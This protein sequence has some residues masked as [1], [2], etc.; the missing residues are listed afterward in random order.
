MG[1]ANTKIGSIVAITVALFIG[2]ITEMDA[3]MNPK[4]KAPPSPMK[5]FMGDG[6][7]LYLGFMIA[8]IS[9]MSPM[10][11][12]TVIATILP[13]FVLA[14]PIL[15]TA[16]AIVRR[17][18]NGRPIMEADKGHLHHKIMNVGMGQKRTVLTLYSISGIMGVAAIL[19]SRDLF[20]DALFL[21]ATAATLIYVF[22]KDQG[23]GKP[24]NGERRDKPESE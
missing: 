14:L 22:M 24:F 19:I 5:I 4:Y 18:K 3:I 12:A 6:G 1:R 10:K 7:A 20:K 8:S 15:D 23:F 21:M 2:L 9:V 16:L 13:I 11:S 17:V